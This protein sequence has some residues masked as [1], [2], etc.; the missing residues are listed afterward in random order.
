MEDHVT[1]LGCGGNCGFIPEV[2]LDQVELGAVGEI[3]QRAF[4]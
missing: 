4:A 1:T 3:V 2:R